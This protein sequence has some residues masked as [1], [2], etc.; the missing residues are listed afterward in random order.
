M[1]T[2]P[3]PSSVNQDSS[4]TG[5]TLVKFGGAALDDPKCLADV[6]R[7][8]A[9]MASRGIPLVV[10]HGGGKEINRALDE[11][12][13]EASFSNGIRITDRK[14]LRLAE[15]ILSGSLNSTIAATVNRSL[16]AESPVRAL[17][18]SARGA[19]IIYAKKMLGKE[20]EDLGQVGCVARIDKRPLERLLA[21]DFIP[22]V[23]PIGEDISGEGALNI[24]ADYAAAAL[25]GALGCKRIVFLTD[26]V[27]VKGGDGEV[28]PEI[29]APK[30]NQ[31]ISDGV[32]NGGMIPKVECALAA[33]NEGCAEA[34]ICLASRI[35]VVGEA[36]NGGLV[37]GTRVC[38]ARC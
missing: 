5:L 7:E 15:G 37:L 16:S 23:S 9:V 22:V 29:S 25:A 30:I 19:G 36:I 10:V 34:V 13:F 4:Q 17:G 3:I 21:A 18:I 2:T 20:G 24:N 8:I 12:G 35:G 32:I 38:M 6:C 1:P 14:T 26:V 28:I 11:L 31:L 33:I 27:G